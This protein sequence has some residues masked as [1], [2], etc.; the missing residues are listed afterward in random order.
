MFTG[1]L[2][3]ALLFG[4]AVRL[5]QLG[6]FLDGE[7]DAQSMRAV[8][9]L[10]WLL[11]VFVA[12][13]G[14]ARSLVT[15]R[16][17]LYQRDQTIA[18]AAST[19]H[20]WLWETDTR[21]AF[22]YCSRGVEELLGYR[23]E[24]LIG[25]PTVDLVLEGERERVASIM[26]T[27]LAN[28]TGWDSVEA[29]WLHRDGYPVALHGSAA[30]I[31]DE[32][33]RVTGFRGTRVR[34]TEAVRAERDAAAA[35]DRLQ[36]VLATC[37]VDV[38]LQPIVSLCSGRLAGVE[39]LARFRDG[40]G[41]DAWFREARE[42]GLAKE[43]DELAFNAALTAFAA[44]P[45]S[46]YVSV[47]ASPALI[48]DPTFAAGLLDS[49]LPLDRLVIEITEH[50]AISD[51]DAVNAALNCLR[52]RGVRLA[53]DDTGAGYASLSHVL[54][55][56][57]DI[58]KIDRSLIARLATDPARRSLVT[59]LVLLAMDIGATVT[60]E[61]VEEAAELDI[62]ATL[63]VDCAQGYLLARPTLDAASWGSW[64]G[65]SWLPTGT[66]AP[67]AP[68]PRAAPGYLVAG[69]QATAERIKD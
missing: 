7:R 61:G 14:L 18:A 49:A 13:G 19:T 27:G 54:Q 63:G 8:F 64:V 24:E 37:E 9:A 56:R 59:A 1:S 38:A 34:V 31:H 2:M 21:H 48:M 6:R 47:N 3:V 51:Y 41:P 12:A 20:D 46:C 29:L 60:G 44:L 45:E 58:V 36:S 15:A 26:A 52:E 32:S 68:R 50:V 4:V 40:R 69:T 33:G 35:R 55:L 22:T 17:L 28:R 5:S 67:R 42:S 30:P 39:A 11:L 66:P 62:L 10:C 65:R 43:L 57:P 16:R 53:V 23:P 25:T